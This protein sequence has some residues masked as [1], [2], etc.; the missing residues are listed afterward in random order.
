MIV[1]REFKPYFQRTPL[2]GDVI[3]VNHLN[4]KNRIEICV[5][6]MLWLSWIKTHSCGNHF[7]T[8]TL[9]VLPKM[10]WYRNSILL[11]RE[12]NKF[13]SICL[14]SRIVAECMSLYTKT[15]FNKI[16]NKLIHATIEFTLSTERSGKLLLS[17]TFFWTLSTKFQFLF[18]L[19]LY[20]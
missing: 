11:S 9:S 1:R 2:P 19:L 5:A 20:S 4:T 8:V 3:V 18:L 17:F 14:F 15:E 16:A 10:V 7:F 12:S 6:A 13:V